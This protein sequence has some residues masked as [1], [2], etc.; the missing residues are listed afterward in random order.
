MIADSLDSS[1][2]FLSDNIDAIHERKDDDDIL[3]VSLRYSMPS[4][5]YDDGREEQ[6]ETVVEWEMEAFPKK[7]SS[8]RGSCL[9][10]E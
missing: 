6:E 5:T 7:D 1:Y 8:L 3:S 9:S 4:P 10:V 2:K